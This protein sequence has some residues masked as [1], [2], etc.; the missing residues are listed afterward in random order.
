MEKI[1]EKL[2]TSASVDLKSLFSLFTEKIPNHNINISEF[3]NKI[4][5]YRKNIQS[6]F[7]NNAEA[8]SLLRNVMV[9]NNIDCL[10]FSS[11]DEYIN[12][13]V[14]EYAQ[15]IRYLTNF[16][17][18]LAICIITLEKA[19]IFVDGRYT[20]Q[21]KNEVD[22]TKFDI[23]YYSLQDIKS[24]IEENVKTASMLGITSTTTDIFQNSTIE[25]LFDGVTNDFIYTNHHLIDSIWDDQPEIPLSQVEIHDIK[26]SGQ[27]AKEK[28]ANIADCLKR[29]N[30]KAMLITA[31][32]EIAWLLNIRGSDIK[33]NP[34][35]LSYCLIQDDKQVILFIDEFKINNEIRKYLEQ[36]TKIV[37]IKQ[38]EQYLS[39]ID[40]KGKI[41]LS[42]SSPVYFLHMLQQFTFQVEIKP[43]C[44]KL[45]KSKKNNIELA[46]TSNAH[47]ED[48]IANIKFYYEVY[49][50]INKSNFTELSLA[51][52]L[53]KYRA[54][55]EFYKG[56]SFD[57]IVG[58]NSNGAIVHYKAN[59]K[60]SKNLTKN[61]YLLLDSGGQYINGTTDLTRTMSFSKPSLDFKEK[62]TMVLKG[63][64]ALAKMKFPIGTKGSALD[65]IA[66]QYLWNIGL[67]YMHGTGHGVGVYGCVHE[68]PISISSACD[69]KF[70]EGMIVSNEPGYYKESEYGIRLENL[71]VV[72]QSRVNGFLEFE[73]LTFVPFDVQ[74]IDF[75]LLT[76][77]EYNWLYDYH[78]NIFNKISSYLSQEESKWLKQYFK[79]I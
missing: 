65:T 8:L 64:I 40:I 67:D 59:E 49:H 55:S 30:L 57:A 50:N 54:Q 70:E 52:L 69:Q 60:T 61:D 78:N 44:I 33:C 29:N 28:I 79:I 76:K 45:E 5:Q 31:T 77:E 48:A 47:I 1:I 74:S 3:E 20:L 17:G 62:F 38:I 43:S 24:W 23:C 14:A 25:K 36:F 34:V 53:Q 26:Y 4:N 35:V 7:N 16:T 46:G 12:E 58:I 73:N 71:Y 21:A 41:T 39:T 56:D 2:A 22:S 42:Q 32:D 19:V 75:D 9:D 11:S 15:R 68:G 13:Y 6:K 72:K 27:C 63:H 10:F 18:S 66:R 37:A 51:S